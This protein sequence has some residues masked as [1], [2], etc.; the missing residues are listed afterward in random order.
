M[1]VLCLHRG[2]ARGARGRTHW[3]G[4]WMRSPLT[5][6]PSSNAL[7]YTSLTYLVHQNIDHLSNIFS[8]TEPCS[9]CAAVRFT[10]CHSQLLSLFT[11]CPVCSE[12]TRGSV[13]QEVGS[14]IQIEQVRGIPEPFGPFVRA[15]VYFCG[16]FPPFSPLYPCLLQV[17]SSCGHVRLWQ[18]Q[19]M[20]HGN[21]PAS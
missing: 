5:S 8:I 20:T 15:N 16:Y 2:S 12:E 13:V 14:F 18:N 19:P 10:V 17:C 9:P 11:M 21:M 6:L 4:R 3:P 1:E 7:Y